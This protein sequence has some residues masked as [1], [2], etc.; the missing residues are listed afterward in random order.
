[1]SQRPLKDWLHLPHTAPTGL[2]KINQTPILLLG[3]HCHFN[4]SK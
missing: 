4:G 2:Q 1:M 3:D